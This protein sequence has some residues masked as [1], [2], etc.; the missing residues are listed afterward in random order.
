MLFQNMGGLG[1]ALTEPSKHM[2]YTL[3]KI[4]RN[5]EVSILGL[6]EVNSDWKKVT[7]K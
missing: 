5:G 2:I 1:N 4:L 6:S 3:K 7:L